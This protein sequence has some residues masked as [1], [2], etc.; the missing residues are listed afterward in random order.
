MNK[1]IIGLGSNI[2][3]KKN[4]KKARDLIAER[5]QV[6]GESDFVQTKPIGYTNQDDFI[7]G[8]IFIATDLSINDLKPVLHEIE[9]DLGRKASPIKFG[10]RT[11]DLDIVVWNNKIID[12]DFHTR[13]FLKN[14]VLQLLPQLKY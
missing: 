11:I 9:Q 14:S 5:F 6:I 10:P 7:N 2:E 4:I 1:A 3:P 8:A 13:D 12:Q